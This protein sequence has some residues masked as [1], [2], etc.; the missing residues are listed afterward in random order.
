MEII[1]LEQGSLDKLCFALHESEVEPVMGVVQIS[2]GMAEHMGRYSH[3]IHFLNQ[4]GFH[5]VIHDHR[6]HG[7]RLT[8]NFKGYFGQPDGWSLVVDDLISIH[9][10]AK[11]TY[12]DLP[13]ILLGHSMGSWISLGALQK[14]TVFDLTL[15]SGSTKPKV[16]ESK[17][18]KL[19]VQFECFRQGGLG[20][21]N[22]LHKLI[23]GGFNSK[24]DNTQS[25]NDW[26]SNDESSVEDYTADPLCGFVVTNQ[27]WLDVIDGVTAVFKKG[28]LE[29]ISNQM[30]LLV[31]SGKD[32]PV[33]GMGQGTTALHQ[34][35]VQAGLK[36]SLLL[37]DGARHETL[38]ETTKMNT[39]N[40]IIT[41]I[42]NNL[43]GV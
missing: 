35:L 28:Q 34:S 20:Y 14:G 7:Q 6:G 1:T 17:V 36:S 27:L 5:V 22:F 23:F 12:P 4:E 29:L 40:E 15:L 39:Y 37:I 41:F 21:S 38:N 9:A 18:Q 8:N 26:L 10:W 30:P 43:T 31:F 2:H 13:H 42:K 19:L 33:G 25:P 3:F 11:Y 32:D 24:F 16:F